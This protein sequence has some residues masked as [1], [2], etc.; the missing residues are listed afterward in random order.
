MH[1]QI[2]EVLF[3]HHST[4]LP[5]LEVLL[6]PPS[7]HPPFQWFNRI[8]CYKN[9]SPTF[10]SPQT[11]TTP[12]LGT[13]PLGQLSGSLVLEGT[14]ANTTP[15][16]LMNSKTY[17]RNPNRWLHI[18]EM[19]DQLQIILVKFQDKEQTKQNILGSNPLI[20]T[21]SKSFVCPSLRST[22]FLL[23]QKHISPLLYYY[24]DHAWC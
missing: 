11:P 21:S 13:Q 24:D 3:N 19:Y 16:R 9:S 20:S 5:I 4:H 14:L 22:I 8:L 6:N 7:T 15:I 12:I 23:I 18:Q 17:T 1:P 10:P 2:S